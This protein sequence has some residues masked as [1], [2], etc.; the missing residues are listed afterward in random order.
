MKTIGVLFHK[1][2]EAIDNNKKV[3]YKTPTAKLHI[4]GDNEEALGNKLREERANPYRFLIDNNFRPITD[5][6]W[7]LDNHSQL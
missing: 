2:E 4:Y 7:V 5:S 3:L 1:Y 6:V